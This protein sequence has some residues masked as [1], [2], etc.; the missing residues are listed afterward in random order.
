M[1]GSVTFCDRAPQLTR[2]AQTARVP[3]L[4]LPEQQPS[5]GSTDNHKPNAISISSSKCKC[6]MFNYGNGPGPASTHQKINRR[7]P[8]SKGQV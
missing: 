5:H 6:D 1:A 7:H 2:I 4:K 3:V 8:G